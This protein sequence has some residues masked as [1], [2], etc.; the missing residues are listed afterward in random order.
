M[1][2]FPT[3]RCKSKKLAHEASRVDE[4]QFYVDLREAVLLAEQALLYTFNFNVSIM[5]PYRYLR[6][7][8]KCF[9]NTRDSTCNQWWREKGED[10]MQASLADIPSCLCVCTSCWVCE[11]ITGS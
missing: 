3:D 11:S 9:Q 8:Y 2:C 6:R 10:W 5:T 1:T 4:Q 7:A